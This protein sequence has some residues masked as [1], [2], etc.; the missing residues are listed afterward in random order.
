MPHIRSSLTPLDGPLIDFMVGVSQPHA[1]AMKAAGTAVPDAI[2]VRGLIDT[3]ASSTAIDPEALKPLGLTP[4][5]MAA[6]T[7][8]STGQTPVQRR[9][10]DVSL[11]FV[12][13]NNYT[14]TIRALPIIECD[15]LSPSYDA[16][17]GR[18]VLTRGLLHYDGYGGTFTLGF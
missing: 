13:A 1:E 3:G 12:L 16:L 11:V 6:V 9:Q 8:P 4:S 2:H 14:Y 7:T 5:G 10:F 15:A 18:D 17:I